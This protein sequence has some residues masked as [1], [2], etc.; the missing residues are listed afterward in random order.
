MVRCPTMLPIRKA[1]ELS[2]CSYDFIR[3]LCITKQICFVRAGSKYLINW[4]KFVDFLNGE[5]AEEIED[6]EGSA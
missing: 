6:P 2:G 5:E 3:K 4:E 1:A